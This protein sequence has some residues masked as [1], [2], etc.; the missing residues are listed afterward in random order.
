MIGNGIPPNYNTNF[1]SKPKE[2]AKRNA[3]DLAKCTIPDPSK[4]DDGG[5]NHQFSKKYSGYADITRLAMA[6]NVNQSDYGTSE[7]VGTQDEDLIG[8]ALSTP[9]IE[10][11]GIIVTDNS[12][13]MF[14]TNVAGS[15]YKIPC[16]TLQN[17]LT[18]GEAKNSA[19]INI[20]VRS[21]NNQ[22]VILLIEA[23]K[24]HSAIVLSEFTESQI[25]GDYFH[26]MT[27]IH[28]KTDTSNGRYTNVYSH[29]NFYSVQPLAGKCPIENAH[30]YSCFNITHVSNLNTAHALL[31]K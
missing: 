21:I 26:K 3:A 31:K 25:H 24:L 17:A 19:S 22:A 6:F 28:P 16:S 18:I 12:E 23:K 5:Y 10:V 30:P 15:I 11:K 29:G 4:I 27:I 9:S 13:Q 2:I 8:F 7:K 14:V 1:S 20:I